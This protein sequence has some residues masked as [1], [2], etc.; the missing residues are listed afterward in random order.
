[1]TTAQVAP[2]ALKART[3]AKATLRAAELLGL[4][5]AELAPILGVSRATVSRIASGDYLIAPEQK[6]WE[7]AALFVRLFRSLDA[8]VGSNE[9]QARAWLNS[10][11]AGLG[12][13]PRKLIP[14]AEG[15]VR[16][17]QYLDAARG[18]S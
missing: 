10:E 18:R 13:I 15:L 3:L 7:L 16:V 11:N 8:L 12:G 17:V 14:K 5:Q 2:D 1:M 4:T 9:A 6:T